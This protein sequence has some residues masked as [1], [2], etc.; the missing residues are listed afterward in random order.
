MILIAGWGRLGRHLSY[1]LRPYHEKILIWHSSQKCLVRVRTRTSG[2]HPSNRESGSNCSPLLDPYVPY[3]LEKETSW[4]AIDSW[5]RV[6]TTI[7]NEGYPTEAVFLT[8]P[9][10]FLKDSIDQLKNLG[11][12]GELVHFSGAFYYPQAFDLHPLASFDYSLLPESLYSAIYWVSS[13]P[14]PIPLLKKLLPFISSSQ[15]I[16]LKPEHKALY[17]ALCVLAG[18][19]AQVLWQEIE[20]EFENIGLPSEVLLPYL[21]SLLPGLPDSSLANLHAPREKTPLSALKVSGPWIRQDQN[22]IAAHLTNL[23]QPL[24]DLYKHLMNLANKNISS[25]PKEFL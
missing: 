19:G 23:P 8:L 9:D 10:R 12:S 6:L 3:G 16:P 17:H 2:P 18:P 22:T 20:R 14:P 5:S 15:L 13:H 7:R 4:A 1:L 11:Y 24:Q 21:H 25:S